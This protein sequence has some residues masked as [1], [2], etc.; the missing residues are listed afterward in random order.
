VVTLSTMLESKPLATVSATWRAVV[1]RRAFL[2]RLPLHFLLADIPLPP[3]M[4]AV[5]QTGEF[6]RE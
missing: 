2:M 3:G 1:T 5:V 4:L 6:T